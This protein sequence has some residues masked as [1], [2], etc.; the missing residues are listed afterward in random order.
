MP[1]KP[2]IICT[3]QEWT[4]LYQILS[5]QC[6]NAKGTSI[7]AFGSRAKKKQSNSHDG[8]KPYSDLDLLVLVK[9]KETSVIA[10]FAQ[11]SES[12]SD[13]ALPY[14][15]DLVDANTASAEFLGLIEPS[16]VLIFQS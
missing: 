13:S 3:D 2:D 7:W 1:S 8:C 15:V 14:K 16:K 11:L 4:I 5:E 10:L 9:A 12:F 6:K